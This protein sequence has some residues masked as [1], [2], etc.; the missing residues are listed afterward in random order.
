[1][2]AAQQKLA[3]NLSSNQTLLKETQKKFD[4]NAE[5]LTGNLKA[6]DDRM[7]KLGK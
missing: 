4:Q 7:K 3:A 1:M 2:E 6:M 5:S